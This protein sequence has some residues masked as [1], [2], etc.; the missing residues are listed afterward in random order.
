MIQAAGGC[1]SI[2]DERRLRE[3][4]GLRNPLL[5]AVVNR[6]AWKYAIAIVFVGTNR[7]YAHVGRAKRDP[8]VDGLSE[9]SVGHEAEAGRVIAGVVKGEIDVAGD[10]VDGKPLVETV[11]ELRELIGRRAGSCPGGTSIIGEGNK[12]VGKAGGS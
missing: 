10:G 3:R 11:H 1:P 12:D 5:V 8:A 6:G 7:A 4:P 9:K 2:S